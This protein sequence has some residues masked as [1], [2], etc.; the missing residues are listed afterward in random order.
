MK[1][2]F[3][4]VKKSFN[5]DARKTYQNYNRSLIFDSK[6]EENTSDLRK[7]KLNS[8]DNRFEPKFED[9][10]P[11]SRKLKEVWNPDA[12]INQLKQNRTSSTFG[13]YK[14]DVIKEEKGVK[15][16]ADLDP[17]KR[18]LAELNPKLGVDDIKVIVAESK[19]TEGFYARSSLLTS[20]GPVS[21]HKDAMVKGLQSN[22]FNDLVRKD[23]INMN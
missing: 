18:K 10:A 5:N 12:D 2:M 3:G 19:G 17:W 9:I 14:K 16:A 7:M 15:N 23:F 11:S 21:S 6:V 22:I 20:E 13:H 1:N 4:E 8:G